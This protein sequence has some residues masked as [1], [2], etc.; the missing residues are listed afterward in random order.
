MARLSWERYVATVKNKKALSDGDI[1]A[2]EKFNDLLI[3]IGESFDLLK[4]KIGVRLMPMVGKDLEDIG[5]IVK[6]LEWI[7]GWID[8]R[9]AKSGDKGASQDPMG[10]AVGW[11]NRMTGLDKWDPFG[12]KA[13]AGDLPAGAPTPALPSPSEL[14][15][16]PRRGT[17]GFKPISFGGFSDDG[18]GEQ[19]GASRIVQVGVFDA[20]VQF[21]S[22]AGVG[23]GTGGV[24]PAAY[25]PGG[26]GPGGADN[27]PIGHGHDRRHGRWRS[28]ERAV[29][30]RGREA[31]RRGDH[32]GSGEPGALR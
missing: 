29:E 11:I 3:E 24:S 2:A 25:H 6:G 1:A 31:N 8:R 10:A 28:Q 26:G 21:Q 7:D 27:T 19:S 22:Y 32:E 4:T 16:R 12:W 23:G 14:N 18:G 9:T 15:A 17:S 30:R 20:L 5:K 13:Q